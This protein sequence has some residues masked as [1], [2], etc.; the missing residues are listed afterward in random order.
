MKVVLTNDDGIDA[1]GMAALDQIAQ[2]LGEVVIVAPKQH[3]SGVGHQITAH[4]PIE[5]KQIHP[6]RFSVQGTPADCSRIAL[7]M[8]AP[9]TDWL[10]SGINAG[11][12]LGSDVY[13]SGT[14]AAARE[15]AILGYPAL[16]ISQYIAQG[17]VIDWP[18]TA[19]YASPLLKMLI[20]KG[21]TDG[22]FWNVNLPHPLPLDGDIAH[23][24][25]RLDTHPHE[26]SYRQEGDN[27]IYDG[28]IHRRPYDQG[29]DVHSCYAGK[30][31]ITKIGI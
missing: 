13:Q 9:D 5:V 14:V 29:T 19:L 21:P 31:A 7:K 24:F 30:I 15:A 8:I 26:Y 27:F 12:N 6:N 1:P 23:A 2:T 18:S 4:E 20:A 22:F 25:C 11:S 10:I 16:A 28:N 3:Q 17:H